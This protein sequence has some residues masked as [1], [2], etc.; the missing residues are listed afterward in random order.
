MAA[1]LVASAIA[2]S[3]LAATLWRSSVENQ[4]KQ[5]FRVQA[6]GVE[7]TV[8]TDI[9]RLD[10]L[11]IA[12]RALLAHDPN[13]TNAE[14]AAW[15]RDIGVAKRYP[16][17]EGFGFVA[18]VRPQSLAAFTATIRRDPAQNLKP[19]PGALQI[20]PA[21]DRAGY[22]LVRLGV[23]SNL[24]EMIPGPGYDL[25]AQAGLHGLLASPTSGRIDAISAQ[26]PGIGQVLVISAPVYRGGSTPSSTQARRALFLG[27]VTSVFDIQSVLG[28]AVAGDRR[29]S[30]GL[31]RRDAPLVA[32]SDSG[33][34]AL[35]ELTSIATMGAPVSHN[36]FRRTSTVNAGGTW[37]VRV[38]EQPSWGPLT[39]G[40]QGLAVL[41]GG[42]FGALLFGAFVLLLAR[43]K[44]KALRLVASKTAELRYQAFHDTLTGLPNRALIVDRAEH[45]LALARRGHGEIAAMYLDLDGFKDINDSAGH[46]VGD[47][48]LR[49]VATRLTSVLRESDT[50]GRFGGDEFVILIDA[51]EV[52]RPELV[53]RRLLDVLD[54]PFF[55]QADTSSALSVSASIGI[56]TG[57]REN[58]MELLRDADI[59]LYAA[60]AGGRNRFAFFEQGMHAAVED[61]LALETDLRAAVGSDQLFLEYQ[62]TFD[63][64]N[65]GLVGVEALI[66]W[67]HPSRGV[68]PPADF[69]P[70]AEE[71]GLILPI[72]HWVL[73]TACAQAA[74]WHRDGYPIEL[75]VN[76][77]ARQLDD[78]Q[79]EQQV[80]ETLRAN[81]LDPRYLT[82][83]ITESLLMR[84]AK[85]VVARLERLKDIGV[86]IAIDDFGTG[87][88]SLAYLEQFPVDA[89]KLDRS[90]IAGIANSSEARA[91]IHSLVQ[92]GK[93]LQLAI[94]AEGIED[95]NQLA[96]L[97]D[98]DCDRGQGFLLA[99]PLSP[100]A[101]QPI[102]DRRWTAR[103]GASRQ[104][105]LRAQLAAAAI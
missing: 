41:L 5:S 87:Y 55:V 76:V 22:C 3:A 21:G 56:A 11:T 23:A 79:L 60:K 32:S 50:V 65:G 48:L 62:P 15:Y 36:A 2:F 86:R 25:C 53:A 31:Q 38:A 4:A 52:T 97:R 74:R 67:Q 81:R 30:V 46:P 91:V 20:T 90:F 1:I 42:T 18:Y 64:A 88:S 63:L 80:L 82:L 104:P 9:S 51:D 34:G 16:G 84:D 24:S 45:A 44:A 96:Q 94:V 83:E 68:I 37:I 43:G 10:D 61:R 73:E 40:E 17:A 6:S 66:R 103:A 54:E 95:A 93:T 8:T 100:A 89:L 12:A 101:L 99:R 39:P 69:I 75:S 13:L 59:A 78:P 102:L 28:A 7:A 85:T 98:E 27:W 92:L 70:I 58:A 26:L 57:L 71:T 14:L 29:L 47:E 33:G 77:S 49:L 105:L 19:L 35:G 72:G